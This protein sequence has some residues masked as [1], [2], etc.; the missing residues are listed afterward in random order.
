M[1]PKIVI[2]GAGGIG[3]A[4]ALIL[5]NNSALLPDI[6]IGDL[7]KTSADS[8]V[9]WVGQSSAKISAFEMPEGE[10]TEEMINIFENSDVLLD[11]LPGKEAPR[12]ARYSRDHNMHYANLTEYVQE[13]EEIKEISK[14]AKTGFVLQTGLAPGF[15]NILAHRLYQEFQEKHKSERLERM[16]MKVGALSKHAPSPHFYAFTWSPI[17]VA[18]EYVKDAIVVKDF[19][20]KMIPAL[21]ERELIN[22]NGKLYE[23]NF[24]SGGAAD[25]PQA[26]EGKIRNID[27]KTLRY[28]GHYEWVKKA[29]K[30]LGKGD[31]ANLLLDKMLGEIP[32]VEEDVVV[33]YSSVTGKDNR[34]VLRCIEKSYTIPPMVLGGQTLRAIQSTTAAPLC[35]IARLLLSGK[36]TGTV[37]QSQIETLEFLNGPYVSS[38]YGR[39]ESE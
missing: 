36:W 7:Y 14:G 1:R 39:Y 23:D 2:A 4:V 38:V 32:A 27:Y 31:K 9:D 21:S 17:G 16:T 33:I 25:L 24:T 12:M 6:Y 20:T 28:P 26:F 18:T 11:C 5:S 8:A 15:I 30:T 10:L 29:I 19:E 34:G 13:T 35:E 3:R 37:L 22:I